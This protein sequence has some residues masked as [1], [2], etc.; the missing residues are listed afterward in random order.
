MNVDKAKVSGGTLPATPGLTPSGDN[1]HSL[2]CMQMWIQDWSGGSTCVRTDTMGTVPR[3]VTAQSE[4]QGR[5]LNKM[6]WIYARGHADS[7]PGQS[8]SR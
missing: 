6:K 4:A 1:A 5:E 8:F 7:K 2:L 3:E